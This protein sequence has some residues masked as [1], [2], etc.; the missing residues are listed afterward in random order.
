MDLYFI[1]LEHLQ[2][3]PATLNITRIHLCNKAKAFCSGWDNYITRNEVIFIINFFSS[4]IQRLLHRIR[5][6]L[7]ATTRTHRNPLYMPQ[8]S[9]E[10]SSFLLNNPTD[11]QLK[12][13]QLFSCKPLIRNL[14]A[15]MCGGDCDQ[16]QSD[17]HRLH[18]KLHQQGNPRD[19]AKPAPQLLPPLKPFL[20]Y[21]SR[22]AKSKRSKISTY[23]SFIYGIWRLS[24]V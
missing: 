20:E 13:S 14:H 18:P 15:Y 10:N 5:N 23:S 12:F 1:R 24:T 11:Y 8:I 4:M 22:H 6:S 17:H 19:L 3:F 9:L 16:N 2:P 7:N 21:M